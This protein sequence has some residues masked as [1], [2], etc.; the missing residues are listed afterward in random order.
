MKLLTLLLLM[1]FLH[2]LSSFKPTPGAVTILRGSSRLFSSKPNLNDPIP[3]RVLASLPALDLAS[4]PPHLIV[5]V[6]SGPDSICLLRSLL[7]IP[8][9]PLPHVVHFDHKT[10]DS[11]ADD[12]SLVTDLCADL[13]LPLHLHTRDASAGAFNQQSS[14]DWRY[15]KLLSHA[16]PNRT[17]LILTGHHSDDSVESFLIK[18]LRGVHLTNFR[19]M[20]AARQL[21]E[22]V[23]V[24]RPL[25]TV[26]KAEIVTY[27]DDNVWK[28]TVDPTNSYTFK[29][30]YFR[31]TVR[32]A[33]V[34]ALEKVIESKDA[35]S[36]DTGSERLRSLV[37]MYSE[38]SEELS[39]YLAEE[40]AKF[41]AKH[42]SRGGLAIPKGLSEATPVSYIAKQA[43]HAWVTE[44]TGEPVAYKNLQRLWAQLAYVNNDHWQLQVGS[45]VSACRYGSLL[46]L[47]WGKDRNTLLEAAPELRKG[48][49][50]LAALV[51]DGV[52]TMKTLNG[53]K[54]KNNGKGVVGELRRRGFKRSSDRLFV[55]MAIENGVITSIIRN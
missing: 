4:P 19:G 28:Y 23:S 50:T 15:D 6:S 20:R 13:S 36:A 44:T 54:M 49:T 21:A 29:H 30:G 32:N 34:P 17:N 39:G 7:L 27:C 41:L 52:V 43:I 55:E 47:T 14:R 9:L 5:S 18:F 45:K 10:R 31:N 3:R 42:A 38:Q 46:Y 40:V 11:T 26:P 8:G 1:L 33:L 12:V 35:D 22:G 24:V 51:R 16:L 2:A 53:V 25:L 37:E 48:R